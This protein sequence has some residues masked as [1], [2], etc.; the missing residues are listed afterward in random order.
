M[1]S[2]ITKIKLEQIAYK[3]MFATSSFFRN[4]GCRCVSSPFFGLHVSVEYG[5]QIDI[6][7]VDS[8]R[9]TI[10]YSVINPSRQSIISWS[11]VRWPEKSGGYITPSPMRGVLHNPQTYE[12]VYITPSPM[13]GGLHNPPTCDM[14]YITHKLFKT[15]QITPKAVLKNHNKSQKNHKMDNSIMLDLE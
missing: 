4:H 7:V 5:Q 12:M 14:V 15:G 11:R 13:R 10:A 6:V 9:M 8:R 3:A 1:L 2:L